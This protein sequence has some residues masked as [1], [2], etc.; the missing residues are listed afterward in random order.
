MEIEGVDHI[1]IVVKSLKEALNTWK[2]TLGLK[3]ERIIE[4][5][6][7]KLK[8]GLVSLGNLYLEFLE[9][10]HA[11]SPVAKFLKKRGGGLH[12][13]AF[14]VK[15]IKKVLDELKSLGI[16]F[17]DERPKM[18]ARG[19]K[20]AFISPKSFSGVLIELTE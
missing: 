15:N 6:D 3:D 14:K 12:H 16:E 13:I 18:G 1:G 9:P 17:I 11:T 8:I 20:I 10:T 7:Y 19:H 2:R 4:A 5:E